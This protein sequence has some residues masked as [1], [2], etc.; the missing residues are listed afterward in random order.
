MH[1]Y[2]S[3]ILSLILYL[4]A[5]IIRNDQGFPLKETEMTRECR[6]LKY[7]TPYLYG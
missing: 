1:K 3:F 4:A 6:T 2:N 7:G 5:R